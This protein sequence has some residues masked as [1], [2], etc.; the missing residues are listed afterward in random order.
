[1][2]FRGGIRQRALRLGAGAG[3][4]LALAGCNFGQ[5]EPMPE[6]RPVADDSLLRAGTIGAETIVTN[7]DFKPLRGFG[8]VV[9]LSGKG[10]SDCPTSIREYLLE[11][12]TK[13]LG[14]L[15]TVDR[16]KL[17]T[18]AELIDSLDT[19]VVEVTGIVPAGSQKN[20]RFD[21]V[22]RALAGTSTQSLEGGLL[23]PTDLRFWDVSATGGG[24]LEGSVLAR[25]E[26][27]VFVNPL[28]EDGRGE[29]DPRQGT[30]LGGG[31]AIEA[32]PFRLTLLR[33]NYSL[34]RAIA[35]RVNERFGQNPRSAEAISMG[36][37][38]L[39]T[40]PAYVR[41]PR[42]FRDLV[43]QMYIESRPAALQEK[44]N[45]LAEYAVLP[46]VDLNRVALAW[47]AIGRAA[48]PHLKPLYVHADLNVRFYAAR[49]GLRL[50]DLAALPVVAATAAAGPPQ[51]RIAA[52]RELGECDSPQIGAYLAP[53]LS[54]ENPEIRIAAYEA[55]LQRGHPTIRSTS[56]RHLL[57]RDQINFILDVVDCDGPPLIYVRRTRLPRIAIFNSRLAVNP[58][59]F[60]APPD[61]SV[62]VHTV[63]GSR[64][65][66]VYG[67]RRRMSEEVVL[68]PRVV[69]LITLLAELP[70]RDELDRLRGLGLPYSAVVRALASLTRDEC[71]AAALHV[72]TLG[73][74]RLTQ[75][76]FTPERQD[77]E[78]SDEPAA[79][80]T[81]VSRK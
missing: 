43:A 11:N 33:P 41:D 26:G 38:E 51:R 23:W 74:P 35:N 22:V 71:I 37:I 64:D 15:G 65:L 39:H 3:L 24:L 69:E 46:E 75:P 31:H 4:L 70:E 29:P 16:R 34:A 52:A 27:P 61:E 78:P 54:D 28:G 48:V 47:E 42:R 32:R 79:A 5:R 8:L 60:Y 57:D 67:K 9:G 53:L 6:P 50:G 10:S 44:L 13:E 68:P 76:E 36:Y 62:V 63:D 49:A 81:R 20:A 55:L 72:E 59:V 80:N 73:V 12:L 1:M 77:A 2:I 19:A 40:P 17:P 66:R 18:P 58:P 21:V 45:Q 56:F 14:P 7:V 25:A 30:I